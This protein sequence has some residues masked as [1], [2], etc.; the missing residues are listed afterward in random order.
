MCVSDIFLLDVIRHTAGDHMHPV[1]ANADEALE[2]R[3]PGRTT[4]V[5][6]EP[7][8]QEARNPDGRGRSR[9]IRFLLVSHT[10][11]HVIG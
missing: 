6:R 4:A 8:G 1:R 7:K 10:G 2:G 11:E 5:G 3:E 9:H